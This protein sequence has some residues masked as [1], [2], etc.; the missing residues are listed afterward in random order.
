MRVRPRDDLDE[1]HM[2][3][4]A[5]ESLQGRFPLEGAWFDIHPSALAVM[6]IRPSLLS[7]RTKLKH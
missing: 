6:N 5:Q 7:S 1:D 4:E 2:G 3:T